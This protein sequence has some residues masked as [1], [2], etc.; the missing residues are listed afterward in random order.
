MFDVIRTGNVDT[1]MLQF[2]I[3]VEAT[4]NT[5]FQAQSITSRKKIQTSQSSLAQTGD[6]KK[7]CIRG[8]IQSC[9]RQ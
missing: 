7:N 6:I 8:I 5:M 1:E 4:E 9:F 2:Y 3:R